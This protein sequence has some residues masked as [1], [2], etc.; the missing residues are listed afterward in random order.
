MCCVIPQ[1]DNGISV[2]RHHA[3][4]M[5]HMLQILHHH[6]W[7]HVRKKMLPHKRHGGG[8]LALEAENLGKN[9]D[10]TSAGEMQEHSK[11]EASTTF[12]KE[13]ATG[14][15][16][17][18]RT[19]VKSRIKALV[20]AEKFKKRAQHHRDSFS[21]VPVLLTQKD[22]CHHQEESDLNSIAEA[23][24]KGA[25]P[26][27][28]H[29]YDENSSASST[30][31]SVQSK[32]IEEPVTSKQARELGAVMLT[33]N[34]METFGSDTLFQEKLDKAKQFLL[35]Q[36]L[37]NAKDTNQNIEFYESNQ[38]LDVL[39][40]FNISK[41]LFLEVLQ[42]PTPPLAHYFYGQRAFNSK[43]GLSKSVSFPSP[44]SFRGR[45][46][47]PSNLK[48][49]QEAK[50]LEN[51][52]V[53]RKHFKN[54]RQKLK[55]VIRENKKEKSRITLDGVLHKIPYGRK[56][57]KNA[58]EEKANLSKETSNK[59]YNKS[60]TQHIG[61]RLSFDGSLDKYQELYETSFKKE[62]KHHI[63]ER[64]KLKAEETPS[65]RAT[66]LKTLGRILSLPNLRSQYYFRNDEASS[67]GI[68]IRSGCIDERKTEIIP[69]GLE[70]DCQYSPVESGSRNNLVE[71]S[72]IETFAKDEVG[73]RS[74]PNEKQEGEVGFTV[75]NNFSEVSIKN[76]GAVDLEEIEPSSKQLESDISLDG[77]ANT[78]DV[79]EFNFVQYVLELSGFSRNDL[80]SAWHSPSQPLDPSIFNKA[81]SSLFPELSYYS[82]KEEGSNFYYLLLFDLI[83]EVLLDI[84]ERSLAYWPG[85]S[86]NF[87][88]RPAPVG[89]HVLEE[90]WADIRGYLSWRPEA[91]QSLDA[92][93]IRDLTTGGRWMNIQFEA[94]AV[95]LDLED[96]IFDDLL[97]ELIWT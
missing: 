8:R 41:E 18:T 29:Q 19:S 15:T 2:D 88:V 40:I 37:G 94:E 30:L 57:S 72:E 78:E 84:Y 91:D 32:A 34:Q 51:K 5:W 54:L 95:G 70:D 12:I 10:A 63:S 38:F 27:I 60:S 64:L 92:A 31:Y 9:I 43:I 93:V 83:N 58:R 24:L 7:N 52:V 81:G 20:A 96:M 90:V 17:V 50:R 13:K 56:F 69:V 62:A 36:E 11:T 71:F 66:A 6:R 65:P 79:P 89:N 3:G 85:L 16:P 14:L 44:G 75:G 48:H 45:K 74:F 97:E 82:E 67:S 33:A 77:L 21:T 22:A 1:S 25:S 46:I 47:R 26:R 59:K 68:P 23:A 86:T 76:P 39:D 4:C 73:S 53:N 61:S 80:L 87:H 49:E 55:H 35:G 42:D 28:L